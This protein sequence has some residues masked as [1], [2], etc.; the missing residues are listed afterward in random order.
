MAQLRERMVFVCGACSHYYSAV[1]TVELGP[2]VDAKQLLDAQAVLMR[3]QRPRCGKC[4]ASPPVWHFERH[5]VEEQSR[6]AV[7]E[8]DQLRE[9]IP[10]AGGVVVRRGCDHKFIDSRRCVKCGWSP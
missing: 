4:H 8:V 5:P 10:I 9:G 6:G 3:E 1:C 2:H 7:S